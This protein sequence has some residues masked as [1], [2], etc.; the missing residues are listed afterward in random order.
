[1]LLCDTSQYPYMRCANNLLEE[2]CLRDVSS[3]L[4][5][6]FISAGSLSSHVWK[7]Q[8]WASISIK[9]CWINIGKWAEWELRM[10]FMS[11]KQ[12]MKTWR[13]PRR[14]IRIQRCTALANM[15]WEIC[16]KVWAS[17]LRPRLLVP[18]ARDFCP[19]LAVPR[20]AVPVDF[21]QSSWYISP[22]LLK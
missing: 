13:T 12:A 22:H 10:T 19:A 1:M 16:S 3:R 9:L 2:S 8:H 6:A 14:F 5:R 21:L 7:I 20:T 15:V 11:P 4:N 18:S 17:L